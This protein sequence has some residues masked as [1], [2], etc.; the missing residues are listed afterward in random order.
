MI[1]LPWQLP[2]ALR[3]GAVAI[4]L[5]LL[6]PL[7]IVCL[8]AFSATEALTFPPARLSWRWFEAFFASPSYYDALMKVSIP[9]GLISS[10]IATVFGTMAALALSRLE[11]RGR[12]ALQIFV[13]SP[14]LIPHILL[15][16]ALYVYFMRIL[17][18]GGWTPLI[19]SHTVIGLPY[20]VRT[21]SAGLASVDRRLEE[22]AI[23]LGATRAQAFAKVTLPLVRTGIVSGALFAFVASFSD[24]NVSLFVAGPGF[25]TLPVQIYSQLQFESDPTIAAASAIQ[26]VL[27]AVA[28]LLLQR[29]TT[30]K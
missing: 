25:G 27:V 10:A 1:P 5:F 7:A 2:W 3:V 29:F 23:S 6:A 16:A 11:F 28:V 15:G 24:V 14:L 26:I 22:A 20:V 18:I 21:V 13:L 9:L 19:V 30:P 12:E 4:F 17:G 8:M